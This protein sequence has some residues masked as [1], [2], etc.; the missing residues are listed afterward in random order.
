MPPL[1]GDTWSLVNFRLHCSNNDVCTVAETAK[2]PVL[3][4]AIFFPGTIE[5][6]IFYRE[7]GSTRD[8]DNVDIPI[9]LV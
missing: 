8:N 4:N 9:I 2:A 5:L 1:L 7:N 3:K 6:I